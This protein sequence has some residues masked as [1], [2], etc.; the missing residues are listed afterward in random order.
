MLYTYK[1]FT[2]PAFEKSKNK[3]TGTQNKK[4]IIQNQFFV[5]NHIRQNK[6][7]NA[8]E[9]KENWW[10][11]FEGRKI[12][13]CKILKKWLS[14]FSNFFDNHFLFKETIYKLVFIKDLQIFNPFANS[15]VFYRN[16]KLV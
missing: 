3:K 2:I 4:Q 1:L 14:K 12:H 13:Y 11:I 8:Q 15:N 9:I 10:Y 5:S 16:L 6:S 7:Y